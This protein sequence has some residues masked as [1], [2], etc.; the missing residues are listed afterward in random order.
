MQGKPD[1]YYEGGSCHVDKQSSESLEFGDSLLIQKRTVL[2]PWENYVSSLGLCFLHKIRDLEKINTPQRG[3]FGT[4]ALW[5]INTHNL[6]S[7]SVKSNYVLLELLKKFFLLLL[8]KETN[9]EL[10]SATNT[11]TFAEEDWPWPDIHDHLPY[12]IHGMWPQHGLPSGAMS[13]PGITRWIP[14]HWS[15]AHELNRHTTGPAPI[16]LFKAQM[17]NTRLK[18]A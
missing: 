2:W 18:L 5:H 6:K 1:F 12:F 3:C 16:S 9:P 11:P 13:T 15:R 17:K 7:R 4:A 14:G 8:F 10:T